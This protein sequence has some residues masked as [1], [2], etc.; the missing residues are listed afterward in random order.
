MVVPHG[1]GTKLFWEGYDL[2]TYS[3]EATSEGTADVAET[4]CFQQTSKTYLAGLKDGTF[5]AG[6]IYDAAAGAS[7]Q[8]L[9]SILGLASAEIL[10]LPEGDTAGKLGIGLQTVETKFSVNS[11]VNDVVA[12]S[13]EGQSSVGIEP[14]TMIQALA[15]QTTTANGTGTDNGALTSLGASAYL[16]VT[17]MSGTGGPTLAVKLQHST[18]N[19][20]YVDLITFTTVTAANKSER[21]AIP[22]GTVNRWLR[23][24]WTITGTTPSFTFT[25]A[26]SRQPGSST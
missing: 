5:S 7:A 24:I 19:I 26:A 13:A 11:P 25:V 16:M 4:S 18:D 15:A 9:E 12:W 8:V 17:A 6:G 14:V 20:T 22:A 23:A 2:S 21:K 3:R 10:H 1:S